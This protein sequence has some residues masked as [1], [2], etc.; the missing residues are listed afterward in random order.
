[1]RRLLAALAAAV[2]AG[3][4]SFALAYALS[5]GI[6]RLFPPEVLGP[7]AAEGV[8][9]GSRSPS[10]IAWLA[11]VF[12]PLYETLLAQTAPMEFARWLRWPALAGVLASA[13]VFGLA[14][15][16]GGGIGHGVVSFAMGL[17]FASAYLAFRDGGALLPSAVAAG[18]H[19]V[20]NAL[21]LWLVH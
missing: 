21:A 20:N 9:D 8:F 13:A 14:H 19:G 6:E 1:V 2:A 3:C 16:L 15:W 4:C 17:V 7:S 18:A 12:A 10:Q 11:V 5:L